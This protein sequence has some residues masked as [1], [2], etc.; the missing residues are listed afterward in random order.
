MPTNPIGSSPSVAI[1]QTLFTRRDYDTQVRGVKT[2]N[3][4]R[5]GKVYAATSKEENL[6]TSGESARADP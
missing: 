2:Q 5:L 4:R 1:D 6:N 3:Q